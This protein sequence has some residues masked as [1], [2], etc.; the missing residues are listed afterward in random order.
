MAI[1]LHS[2]QHKDRLSTALDHMPDGPVQGAEGRVTGKLPQGVTNRELYSDVVRIAWPGFVELILTQLAS[3]V[4][5]MMV[6]SIGGAEHTVL[7][8]QALSAVGLTNQPKFLLM[9]A[10]I[11]MNTGVTAMVARCK[12]TGEREKANLVVR[13]GLLFTFVSTLILSIIGIIFSRPMVIFMGSTEETVTLWATQYLQIQLAGFLT[14]ALTSTITAALRGVGDSRSSMIYNLIANAVNVV[15]N[16]LLIYGNFG[17][18]EMG[19][20]GAS[21]ATVIGQLV[22]FVIAL[23]IILRGN[24]FLKLEMKKGFRWHADRDVAKSPIPRQW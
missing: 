24:G 13:Q 4:D 3:M 5:L 23:G 18:P 22:A 8:A 1:P 9:A 10:F 12:G 14:M 17:F 16:Y 21:I 15:F 7:G 11:A 2:S 19:V 20:A 6:G